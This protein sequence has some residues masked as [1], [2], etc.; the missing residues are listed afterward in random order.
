M[1]VKQCFRLAALCALPL[2]ASAKDRPEP[3]AVP[4]DQPTNTTGSISYSTA[5]VEAWLSNASN[6]PAIMAYC[7]DDETEESDVL[8]IDGRHLFSRIPPP[9][10]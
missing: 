8:S 3:V 1:E 9:V 2:A 7:Y 5:S 10:V 4:V 6:L